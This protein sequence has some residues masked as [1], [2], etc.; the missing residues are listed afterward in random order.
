MFRILWYVSYIYTKWAY[1][2]DVD[3]MVFILPSTSRNMSIRLECTFTMIPLPALC[4]TSPI[5]GRRSSTENS[6]ERATTPTPAA[7][8]LFIYFQW[9]DH[10][11]TAGESQPPRAEQ[12]QG[13]R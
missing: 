10:A 9:R 6:D 1:I 11:Q 8:S 7:F 2:Y 12:T 5:S 3:G 4:M 13:R